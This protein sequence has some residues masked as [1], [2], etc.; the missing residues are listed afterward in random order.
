MKNYKVHNLVQSTVILKI[1]RERH[2]IAAKQS[3]DVM[4]NQNDKLLYPEGTLNIVEVPKSASEPKVMEKNETTDSAKV[5]VKTEVKTEVKAPTKV[6]EKA[7][8]KTAAKKAPAKKAPA[9]KA[10][11][12]KADV[13]IETEENSESK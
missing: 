9:K 7:A 2:Q 3:I 12:K 11:A 6:E 10:P 1:N 8:P 13:K 4:F 5:E